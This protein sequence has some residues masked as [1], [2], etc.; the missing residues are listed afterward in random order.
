MERKIA[1]PLLA[2]WGERAPMHSLYDVPA[3]WRER[4]TNVTG[5]ALPGTHYFAEE[6]PELVAQEFRAF[7]S[8]AVAGAP[9]P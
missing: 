2:L 6:I 4:A 1:C 9:H 7:F 8:V 3:T 5:K